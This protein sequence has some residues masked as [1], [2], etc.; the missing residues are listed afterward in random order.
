MSVF[1]NFCST[2]LHHESAS[3]HNMVALRLGAITDTAF[4][5]WNKRPEQA[6]AL[7]TS[8][9]WT[10][11]KVHFS[12]GTCLNEIYLQE[13]VYSAVEIPLVKSARQLHKPRYWPIVEADNW[14]PYPSVKWQPFWYTSQQPRAWLRIAELPIRTWRTH[15]SMCEACHMRPNFSLHCRVPWRLRR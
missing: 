14:C 7:P 6:H 4:G 1:G 2:F 13:P 8:R 9:H 11:L 3:L 5:L 15:D 12:S 10:C